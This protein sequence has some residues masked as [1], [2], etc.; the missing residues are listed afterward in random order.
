M[1]KPTVVDVTPTVLNLRQYKLSKIFVKDLA[2]M[3]E[4]V[5]AQI[6]DLESY[7]R[8]KPVQRILATLND[9]LSTL[10]AHQT[11]C[12]DIVKNKGKVKSD[13]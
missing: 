10:K 11:K 4:L 2:V 3:I 6:K 13:G 7:R 12:I 8:Y 5:Q 1:T 9:E